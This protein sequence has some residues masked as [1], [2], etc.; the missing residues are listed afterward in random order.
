M[1]MR[2]YSR[3]GER[4]RYKVEVMDIADGEDAGI[5]SAT[6]QIKGHNAYGWLKTETGVHRL[7]RIS[8]FDQAARR[9]TSF[10]SV[11][12]WPEFDDEIEIDMGSLKAGLGVDESVNSLTYR[13]LQQRRD[14]INKRMRDHIRA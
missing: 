11:Y 7:V 4:R 12:V 1:L 10:A 6:L 14:L 13:E 5:K 9:H 8:P 2:M 3:W